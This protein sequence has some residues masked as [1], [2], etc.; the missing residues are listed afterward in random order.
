MKSVIDIF[1]ERV[2]GAINTAS[3]QKD[4]AAIVKPATD[5]KFG[6]YQVNGIMPLAKKLKTNPRKLAEKVVAKL[7]LDDICEEPEIAG[8]GF[9]NLRLKSDFAAKAIL[10]IN[11]DPA[12]PAR[13]ITGT[14][15]LVK[16]LGMDWWEQVENAPNYA[17]EK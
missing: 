7:N 15:R 17:G 11:A 10:E 8:P 12:H 1:E 14:S 13:F 3:G 16:A 2:S 6:D 5:P 4:C 9:I